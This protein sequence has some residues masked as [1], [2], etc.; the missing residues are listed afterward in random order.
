MKTPSASHSQKPALK[1]VCSGCVG[2]PFLHDLIDREGAKSCCTYCHTNSRTIT[3]TNLAARVEEVFSHHYERTPTEPSGFEAA[4]CKDRDSTS[5]WERLGEPVLRAIQNA[6]NVSEP[7][8]NDILSILKDLQSNEELDEMGVEQ[9][10]ADSSYYASKAPDCAEYR[11]EWA[12]FE[13]ALKTEARFLS[14]KARKTLH[15]IFG[16][17]SELKTTEGVAIVVPAGPQTEYTAIYRAR[18]FAGEDDKLLNALKFPWKELGPPPWVV[19]PAGRMN[20]RGISVF[21]GACESETALNEVRPPVGSQVAIAK[22][23]IQRPLRLLDVGALRSM[24]ASESIFHPSCL[25][26]VQRAGFMLE[27]SQRISRPIMPNEQDFEYLATQAIAEYLATEERLDGI[28]FQSTQVAH[29]AHNVVL[30]YQA[31]RVGD[32]QIPKG[33]KITARLLE[34]DS[35][36]I[37]PEYSVWVELPSVPVTNS[38]PESLQNDPVNTPAAESCMDNRPITL[39]IDMTSLTISYITAVHYRSIVYPVNRHRFDPV[40]SSPF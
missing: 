22:F 21:Y 39:S 29:E 27:L 1:I 5:G 19:A 23:D 37:Y 9:P 35:E 26:Q 38:T 3:I 16:G 17:I 30:F 18:V 2:E 10:F 8:A 6:A 12:D 14:L 34:E 28:I 4:M 24:A 32:V 25:S 40:E 31:S 15:R 20:A 13:H 33:A 7:V 36:D 11:R